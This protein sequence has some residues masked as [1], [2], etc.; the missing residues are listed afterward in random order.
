MEIRAFED[1]VLVKDL[2]NGHFSKGTLG[3]VADVLHE[4]KG[5]VVEF[6]AANGQ[7]LGVEIVDASFVAPASAFPFPVR[8]ES[9]A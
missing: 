3:V 7:T 5:F 8:V 2:T 4:G 9:A 6:F 1:V